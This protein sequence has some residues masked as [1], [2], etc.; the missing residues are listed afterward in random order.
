[1]SLLLRW[2]CF[3][4]CF[5]SV[6]L[7]AKAN[8]DGGK[9]SG[10]VRTADGLPAAFITVAVKESAQKTITN[11]DGVF[12]LLQLSAG[13]YT[14]VFTATGFDAVEKRVEL[15]EDQTYNLEIS[16][17]QSAKELSQVVVTG[18][19][20]RTSTVT[21][22]NVPLL[23][24]PMSIQVI[25]QQ[26]IRQQAAFDI[27]DIVRNV[28]GVAQTGSYNGGYQ[29]FNSRGFDM[30]NWTNFRRNGTLLWNMGNHY[31]DFYESVEFLKG[32]SAILY[33]D[34]AP[35]GIMNFVTKKPLAYNYGR[36]DLRVGQY[37]L[38]RP[39]VDISGP[40]DAKGKLLYRFNTSYEKSGSFRNVVENKTVMVA[41]ALT[42]NIS[43]K[44]SWNVEL[45]YKKDERIGDPGLV[46]PDG[47]FEG[48][49]RISEKTFLGER[50]A[51]YTYKNT[52]LFSNFKYY[53]SKQWYL[54]QTTSVMQTVRTP[55]NVYVNNDADA[56]GNVSRYQYFF[57]Q[58]FDTKTA[59]LDAVG[60]VAT[61]P[62]RHKILVG[63]DYVDDGIRMGGF[64]QEDI[65]GTINLF[66]PQQGIA[67]LQPLPKAWDNNASFTR[68]IGVYAQ[69]QL[70]FF[71]D[72][73]HLLMGLRYNHYVSGTRYDNEADKPADYAEVVERPVVP[74]FGAVYKPV[75]NISVYGSFAESYEVNGFDWI[76]PKKQVAP[77]FG[78]QYE[79]GVKADLL[80]KRLGV[81]LS[82]FN[83]EKENAYNWGY[84]D[85]EPT[86]DYI[87][88]TT[89]DGGWYT[90]QAKLH[91]S[92][93]IELDINGKINDNLNILA[94][95][96]Y[97]KAEVVDDIVYPKGNWL[98]NQPREM[99]S[100]WA[101]Y[102][103]S[104]VLKGLSLGYGVFYKGDFFADY[105]NA[106]EG[107][108]PSNYTMD[109]AVGYNWKQ[110]G[111]QLNVSNFTNRISYLG[112][113]GAWEP[114]WTRRAVFT[115]SYKL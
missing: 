92:R 69:D 36:I 18:Q 71:N 98:S 83:I 21:K 41:P 27:K 17:T 10:I 46:S 39:A 49:R 115:L 109:A 9:I 65:G 99:F 34:V 85:A 1:M 78:R 60:E 80:K 61:G 55:L 37:G 13:T 79:A 5:F 32:P 7:N 72:K 111:A 74:R 16:L 45:N 53:L 23:D 103:F 15:G 76:D 101:N 58:K 20:R 67:S 54:Q 112:A 108:V 88:W 110:W 81:T 62:V 94:T 73:V 35:G 107:R 38:F 25:D 50:D 47:T 42:W 66:N 2:L 64:L 68:R 91:R 90:Y 4:I 114:Q 12:N 82:V 75:Q 30:N 106:P 70:S 84:S 96:S 3:F 28:S 100:L 11:E 102:K 44:A 77:T 19:K 63:A 104:K 51:T 29:Y 22:T 97:I 33:G 31:A 89:Q 56:A 95:G 14:L 26:I 57:R 105:T 40:I 93:G 87:S 8:G 59:M 86:F 6:L 24:I 52:A 43:P 113:F 48:L